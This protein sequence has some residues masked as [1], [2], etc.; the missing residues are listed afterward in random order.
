VQIVKTISVIPRVPIDIIEEY[1]LQERFREYMHYIYV[2]AR[3][4]QEKTW[5][6]RPFQI[7]LGEVQAIMTNCKPEWKHDVQQDEVSGYED[8]EET[9]A[10]KKDEQEEE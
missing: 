8:E 7:N 5:V 6:P 2:C 10:D 9:S 4:D 3:R 1:R